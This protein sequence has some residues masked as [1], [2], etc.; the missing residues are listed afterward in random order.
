LDVS[1]FCSVFN[2]LAFYI[3]QVNEFIL[4]I[5]VYRK[6]SDGKLFKDLENSQEGLGIAVIDIGVITSNTLDA[7]F[8]SIAFCI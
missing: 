4:N 3:L 6:P 2:F 5:E 1:T 7:A 8:R